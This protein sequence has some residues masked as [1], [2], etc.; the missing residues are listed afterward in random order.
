MRL[1]LVAAVAENR[2]IGRS[3]GLPWRLPGELGRFKALTMGKPVIMGRRTYRD[4][5]R[6]L[7]GRRNIVIS[8]NRSLCIDGV[9]V[10]H[11]LDAALAA[12]AMD[13][14]GE[15]MVIGGAEIYA[16]ALPRAGRMYLTE[17]HAAA[18]GE[19]RFPAFDRAA[20]HEASREL[21]ETEGPDVPNYSVVVLDRVTP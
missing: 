14:G 16:M 9:S 11:G 1:S 6:P 4:I 8:R 19:T 3:G 13:G 15:V 7:P 2:V 10:V 18:R 20:W 12:A 17:V 21:V 5:G